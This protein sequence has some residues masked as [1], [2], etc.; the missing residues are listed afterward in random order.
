MREPWII[1]EG[2]R[3]WPQSLRAS[4]PAQSLRAGYCLFEAL[5]AAYE[6]LLGPSAALPAL[7]EALSAPFETLFD[8][9]GALPAATEDLQVLFVA[10]PSAIV[11]YKAA[12]SSLL[13]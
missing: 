10:L 7:S 8:P 6:A 9:S 4:G 12:A 2:L 13:S 1:W 11:L 5:P 3:D